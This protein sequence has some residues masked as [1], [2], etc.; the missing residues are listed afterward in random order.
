MK[1]FCL[2][3]FIINCNFYLFL[4]LLKERPSYGRS[5]QPSKENIQHFKKLNF[6]TFFLFLWVIV[7]LL[8]PNPGTPLNPDPIRVRIHNTAFKCSISLNISDMVTSKASYKEVDYN[9]SNKSS[10]TTSGSGRG[11]E[12]ILS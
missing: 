1:N 9:I 6:L 10:K 5:L 4:G 12:L 7:A 8:D 3:F 2:L 11:E